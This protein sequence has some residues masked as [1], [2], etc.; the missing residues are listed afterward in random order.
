[1]PQRFFT[2]QE[3][4]EEVMRPSKCRNGDLKPESGGWG[5]AGTVFI[6]LS[7]EKKKEQ[8]GQKI[9]QLNFT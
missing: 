8:F 2:D 6:A 1:M 5:G 7:K 9:K 4:S 3:R